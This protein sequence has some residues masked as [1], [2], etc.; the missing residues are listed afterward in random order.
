MSIELGVIPKG[1]DDGQG[2]RIWNFL[3]DG[4]A[5]ASHTGR[6]VADF[7]LFAVQAVEIGFWSDR[8]PLAGGHLPTR[9]TVTT[10]K[11]QTQSPCRKTL[12]CIVESA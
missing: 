8:I 3:T 9:P 12:S 11:I 1:E 2:N 7:S 4:L 5:K 10:T 6:T